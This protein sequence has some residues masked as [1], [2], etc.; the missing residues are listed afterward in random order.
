[1]VKRNENGELEHVMIDRTDMP[2]TAAQE[3]AFKQRAIDAEKRA[4]A[5]YARLNTAKDLIRR[6]HDDQRGWGENVYVLGYEVGAFLEAERVI[7]E[8][9]LDAEGL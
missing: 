4:A 5:I 3:D 6:L 1:M 7:E 8:S 9:E 2:L